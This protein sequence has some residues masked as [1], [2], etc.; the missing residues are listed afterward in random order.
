MPDET[1]WLKWSRLV[2][3]VLRSTDAI[4]CRALYPATVISSDGNRATVKPDDE[5]L[6]LQLSNKPVRRP[7]GF[8]A[9]PAPGMRCLI[10]W[11]GYREEGCFVLLGFDGSGTASSIGLKANVNI[12]LEAALVNLGSSPAAAFVLLG[13]AGPALSTLFG[14]M[15]ASF[16]AA[17]TAFTAIGVAVPATAAACG[18]AA[19]SFS[20]AATACG[21]FNGQ[22]NGFVAT[23][24]KA[25]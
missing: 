20:S 16:T 21:T 2:E 5:R 9:V 17:A 13:T 24:V 4:D 8:T 7:D 10:G 12:D 14:A 1:M 22:I 23:K 15:S 3:R 25:T 6:G 18:A 11:D 19:A